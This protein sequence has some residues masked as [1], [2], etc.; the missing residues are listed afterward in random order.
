MSLWH[1][2]KMTDEK[3]YRMHPKCPACGWCREWANCAM[4]TDTIRCVNCKLELKVLPS[5]Y[6]EREAY[7]KERELL[8]K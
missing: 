3:Y 6:A 7:F 4:C 5:V 2:M 1:Q 8:C